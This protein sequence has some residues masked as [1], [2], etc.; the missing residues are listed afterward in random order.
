MT[1]NRLLRALWDR[2]LPPGGDVAVA[3]EP[4]DE[5]WFFRIPDGRLFAV[6]SEELISMQIQPL[7]LGDDW[8]E[9]SDLDLCG[10]CWF[11]H[12]SAWHLIEPDGA[13]RA[14]IPWLPHWAIAD[15]SAEP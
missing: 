9:P 3:R 14:D 12:E 6:Q 10:R 8:P 4:D 5:H 11:W 2:L 13:F 7:L 15:P 1:M